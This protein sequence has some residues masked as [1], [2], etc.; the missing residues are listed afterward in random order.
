MRSVL[1]A[2]EHRFLLI[3]EEIDIFQLRLKHLIS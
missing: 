1:V 3:K 2:E